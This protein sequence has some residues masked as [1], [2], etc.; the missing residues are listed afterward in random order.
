MKRL[1][2]FLPFLLT[3]QFCQVTSQNEKSV[4]ETVLGE[5]DSDGL[6][7]TLVHE[8][9]LVD[10]IGADSTGN[11]RWEIDEVALFLTPFL[12][13][14]M[15]RGVKTMI[16]CTPS[17]LGKDP[18]LLKILSETTGMQFLTNVGY[19][20]AVSGKY[21]PSYAF[22]ESAEELAQRWTTEAHN[23]IAETK[24][25]PGFIKIGVN[26]GEKLSEMDAKLVKAAAITHLETGLLIV[27]HTGSWKTAKAQIDLLKINNVSPGNFVWVHA[28]NE[29]DF[30]NYRSAHQEGVWISLDGIVW[31]VKGHLDR[32]LFIKNHL[33]LEK[34]LISHDAGWY[35]PGEQNQNNFKGYTSLFD[36]L[37]PL[38]YENGFT[39]AD[40][41][42]MLIENP[43]RAFSLR[44]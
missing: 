12:K 14:A 30:E 9:V 42:K 35:S 31:D 3:F 38:L 21:L 19:Y 16:E 28:Q 13:E 37:I 25:K 4:I 8:H 18:D 32:L 6:G 24:V 10:F 2:P 36:E 22:E 33:D 44:Y 23:G 43:K 1:L 11:H 15:D 41:D 7:I 27:S 17:Y 20:G 29:M 39:K 26:E 40:V 34:V 5:I